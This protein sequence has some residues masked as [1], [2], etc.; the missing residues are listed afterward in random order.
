MAIEGGE[1]FIDYWGYSLVIISFWVSILSLMAIRKVTGVSVRKWFE[2][3]VLILLFI[4]IGSFSRYNLLR[5]YFYFE[6]SL[7]PIFLIILG[8]GYQPERLQAGLYFIFY[9]LGASLPLLFIIISLDWVMGDIS[10]FNMVGLKISGG[11]RIIFLL[12]LAAFLVKIP[13]VFTH[14]WLPKAHVEAPVSG[15][16]ILAGVLLKLGGYGLSRLGGLVFIFRRVSSYIIGLSLMG[17]AYV[18]LICCQINDL[19]ALIAYSSVAHMG[20]VIRGLFRG[21]KWGALGSLVI[22]IGHGVSSS[23]LF[24]IANIYYERRV[25]R[26]I[27]LN[28]GLV[29]VLPIG[30]LIF[31][32]LC[33]GNI[34]VPP[35]INFWSEIYLMGAILGFDTFIIFV[36][37]VGSFLGVVFTILMY[38]YTQHG[39]IVVSTHRALILTRREVLIMVLHIIPLYLVFLR[40]DVLFV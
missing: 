40:I 4:L 16:I 7:I 30:S 13:M 32:L 12:T 9:T 19:K 31:F 6:S 22:I 35:T 26:R 11:W 23:G 14:L 38:S 39:K 37:P 36:F 10:L 21:L 15:S 2:V 29:R 24:Y 3:S 27:F 8:F 1:L 17:I 5:F 25:R 20:L 18:R 34:S 28:K 33:S